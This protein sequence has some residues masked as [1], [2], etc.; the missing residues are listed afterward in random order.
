MIRLDNNYNESFLLWCLLL[1][2]WVLNQTP[3]HWHEVPPFCPCSATIRSPSDVF[4]C[5]GCLLTRRSFRKSPL[6]YHCWPWKEA[7]SAARYGGWGGKR[8]CWSPTDMPRCVH[9]QPRQETQT[10]HLVPGNYWPWLQVSDNR[11]HHL[12]LPYHDWPDR[13]VFCRLISLHCAPRVSTM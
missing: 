4:L 12:P 13:T 7:G 8:C 5:I 10:E 11:E 9:C 3:A 6:P 1:D 2:L